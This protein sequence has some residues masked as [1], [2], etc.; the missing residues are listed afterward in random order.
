[1]PISTLLLSILIMMAVVLAFRV[2]LIRRKL[3]IA[4]GTEH[5][6]LLRASRAHHNFLENVPLA[7]LG[8]GLLEF[9][10]FSQ[11]VLGTLAA[12]FVVGRLSHAFGISR[13]NEDFRFRVAGMVLTWTVMGIESLLLLYVLLY[14]I[15]QCQC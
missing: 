4:V 15:I 12:T 6:Q 9:R 7:F 14:P 3:K 2:M 1:M 8:I 5:P 11:V 10:G 13:L